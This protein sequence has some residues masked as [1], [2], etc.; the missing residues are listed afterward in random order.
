MACD[1]WT[2]DKVL[3]V[4]T[5]NKG[6]YLNFDTMGGGVTRRNVGLYAGKGLYLPPG[7]A[8][9][10]ITDEMGDKVLVARTQGSLASDDDIPF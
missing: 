6:I 5:K 9:A 2:P 7:Y 4:G 8:Y 1:K 3:E 10:I